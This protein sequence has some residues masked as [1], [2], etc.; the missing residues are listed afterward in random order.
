[1]KRNAASFAIVLVFVTLTFQPFAYCQKPVEYADPDAFNVYSALMPTPINGRA[2][3]VVDATRKAE[4]CS[5]N[6]ESMPDSDFR[7]AMQDFHRANKQV[8]TLAKEFRSSVQADL[9]DSKELKSYFRKSA[10]KGW[11]TFYKTHP[12]AS[13]TIAFSAVGF[14]HKRTAAVV[15]SEIV[16][17]SECGVGGLH[18]LRKEAAGWTEIK[19]GF[20]DCGWIS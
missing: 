20:P 11:K 3:L 5:L 9:I 12:Q 16:S 6:D 13:G 4:R 7:E 17:C 2:V 8:W 1:M 18:F 14:N 10:D 19:P 15:Y